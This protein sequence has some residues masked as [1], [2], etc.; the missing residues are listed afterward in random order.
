[1]PSE[2]SFKPTSL[3][4]AALRGTFGDWTYY[5]AV[6]PIAELAKRVA[7]A[8]EIHT[9]KKLSEAIQRELKGGAKGGRASDIANYLKTEPERFFNS[10]VVAVYGG[11]PEWIPLKLNNGDDKPPLLDDSSNSL[12]VLNMTGTE[13][14]FAVDG[15]HRLAGMKRLMESLE[16]KSE[17]ENSY[18]PSDMVSVLFIAHRTDKIERTRRLFT[19][20]NKTAVPVSKMERIAL[21][22]NDVMA[23][24]TRR[25][26]EDNPRFN[27][28]RIAMNHTNNLGRDDRTALTTIGNLYDIL[29]LLFISE[30]GFKKKDLQFTRP[31]DSQLNNFY[32]IATTFF[33]DLA[34]IEPG[35]EEYF[36]ATNIVEVCSKFRTTNG[37][38]IYFRPLGLLLMTEVAL[39]L[40]AR[41]SNWKQLMSALPKQLSDF[42]FFGTIWSQR[43]TIEPKHKTLCRDLLLYMCDYPVASQSALKAKLSEIL[44]EDT[45]LPEKVVPIS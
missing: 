41:T 32:E 34:S 31:N 2:N 13:K 35:L 24:I 11:A 29:Q 21:D 44:G 28:L 40:K 9:N 18:L 30:S 43:N 37:G 38:S 14:L 36:V 23:I 27:G 3:A 25:L 26:V 45:E 19:T 7:F 42:P 20:L 1:M 4:L 17:T 10:L 15:Q 22:E 8:T 16:K 5:S 39:K 12:G 33:V 6:V